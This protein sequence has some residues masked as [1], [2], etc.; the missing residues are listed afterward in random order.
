MDKQN[1]RNIITSRE[2]YQIPDWF[3]AFVPHRL[4]GGTLVQLTPLSVVQVLHGNLADVTFNQALQFQQNHFW[5]LD[6]LFN[7]D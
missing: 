3:Y 7:P 5:V 1:S 6:R 4:A 2:K